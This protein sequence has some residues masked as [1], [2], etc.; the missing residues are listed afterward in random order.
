MYFE[1][2]G[3][4]GDVELIAEGPSVRERARL[5]TQFGAGR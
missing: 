5:K 1:I 3:E 2:V 4:I